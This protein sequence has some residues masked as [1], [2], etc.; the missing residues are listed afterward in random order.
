MILSSVLTTVVVASVAR[1]AAAQDDTQGPIQYD[2]AH[3]ATSIVG[4]WSTG[5]KAVVTG[6]VRHNVT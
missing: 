2:L 1:F 5:S 4:T 6:E 3:N